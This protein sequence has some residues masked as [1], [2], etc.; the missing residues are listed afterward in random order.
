MHHGPSSI[1]SP[2]KFT[3]GGVPPLKLETP[4]LVSWGGFSSLPLVLMHLLLCPFSFLFLVDFPQAPQSPHSLSWKWKWMAWSSLYLI[5]LH[6]ISGKLCQLSHR[7]SGL[8]SY[9]VWADGD[10]CY[11]FKERRGHSSVVKESFVL[12]GEALPWQIWS[13]ALWRGGLAWHLFVRG[14]FLRGLL[15]KVACIG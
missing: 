14:V 5:N 11:Q 15:K 6:I 1:D 7:G 13:V 2:S 4:S 9:L 3:G 12:P 8:K 10:G